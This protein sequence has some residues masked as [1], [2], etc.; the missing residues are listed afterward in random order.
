MGESLNGVALNVI[1]IGILKRKRVLKND[2]KA[3]YFVI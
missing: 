3:L 2:M 1:G